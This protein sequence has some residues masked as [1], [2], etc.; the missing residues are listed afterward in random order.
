LIPQLTAYPIAA[1]LVNIGLSPFDETHQSAGNAT[2]P[3]A[4]LAGHPALS[5]LLAG[6][7]L[8][9]RCFVQAIP[10]KRTNGCVQL[11]IQG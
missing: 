8:L 4:R 11:K 3:L 6:I 7:S 2:H 10:P 5:R 9:R 1:S